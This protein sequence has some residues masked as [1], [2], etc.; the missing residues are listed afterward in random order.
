MDNNTAD[1]FDLSALILHN[2]TTS[3]F[4]NSPS[5]SPAVETAPEPVPRPISKRRGKK[6][7]SRAC[8][9]CRNR[10]VRC[11]IVAHGAPC[12]NC[13]HD[14][15]ECILPLSRRQ[16]SARERAE[17]CLRDSLDGSDSGDQHNAHLKIEVEQSTSKDN[18][19]LTLSD[20][21]PHGMD[22]SEHPL[23]EILP[24][25]ATSPV[26][27]GASTTCPSSSRTKSW[28]QIQSPLASAPVLN[29]NPNAFENGLPNLPPIFTPFPRH[30]D[31]ADFQYLY[32]RDALT[33]PS[34]KLQIPLLKA[35]VNHVHGN[36][37]IL[38]VEEFLSVVKYG[39]GSSDLH[40]GDLQEQTWRG[41]ISFLLF[42]AV[43]FA[44][45]EFVGLKALEEAGWKSREDCSRAMA[46]RVKLL[47]DFD[48]TSDRLAIVQALLLLTLQKPE[49]SR[50]PAHRTSPTKNAEHHLNLAISLCYS[51][52]LHRTLPLPES[53]A[54]H[55]HLSRKRRLERRI[56]WTAFIRDRL[57]AI[58]SD[59]RKRP[60]HIKKEDCEIEQL[61]IADFDMTPESGEDD[62]EAEM[63]DRVSAQTFIEKAILCW[64]G[65]DT[66]FGA[67]LLGYNKR[68]D[69]KPLF[70]WQE[71][72]ND[73]ILAY[74]TCTL[75]WQRREELEMDTTTT[76]CSFPFTKLN[77]HSPLENTQFE[78]QRNSSLFTF[79]PSSSVTSSESPLLTPRPFDDDQQRPFASEPKLVFS[80]DRDT[81]L[82]AGYGVDGEYDDY[83]EL[84]RPSIEVE[85]K[86]P[87]LDPVKGGMGIGINKGIRER[88]MGAR[89][90]ELDCERGCILEV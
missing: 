68:L 55:A 1:E 40:R 88:G 70:P 47:Y 82:G 76:A 25:P 53:P 59:G 3:P 23:A 87:S 57:L 51:L 31:S 58:S 54:L 8:T 79:H 43:M 17:R 48:T 39:C 12:S 14:E 78:T 89:A 36:I 4:F 50:R 62:G 42:Q 21:A 69:P 33:V 16:R 44:A 52:G 90:F 2:A 9:T 24:F 27:V 28:I 64:E 56:F 46:G 41:K 71:Q 11:N 10:K 29:T 45:V 34:E 37:P 86:K 19:T 5:P 84:L 49:P 80:P 26:T 32:S 74:P 22:I 15:I 61:S 63:R 85:V 38:D 83:L 18:Q 75:E 35:Y 60:V 81:D 66:G 30:L 73:P 65:S 72:E 7:S 20:L 6:R 13:R 77:N 67:A